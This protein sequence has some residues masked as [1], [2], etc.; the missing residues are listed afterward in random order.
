MSTHSMYAIGLFI[1]TI[2]GIRYLVRHVM[3][4]GKIR[5]AINDYNFLIA[6]SV[7]TIYIFAGY[8]I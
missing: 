2:F 8:E 4:P 6:L 3:T 1:L 7:M 5:R